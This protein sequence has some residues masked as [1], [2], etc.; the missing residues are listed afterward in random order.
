METIGRVTLLKVQASLRRAEAANRKGRCSLKK[1]LTIPRAAASLEDT[2]AGE[3]QCASH[4]WGVW[5]LFG[6]YADAFG[7]LGM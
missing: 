7:A 4:L 2:I 5:G 3:R 1:V 6:V